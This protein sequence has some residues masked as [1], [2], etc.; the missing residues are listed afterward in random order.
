M[1]QAHLVHLAPSIGIDSHD[2]VILLYV[3]AVSSFFSYIGLLVVVIFIRVIV[4]TCLFG[5]LV[6]SGVGILLVLLLILV[7]IVVVDVICE[8]EASTC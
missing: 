1:S 5:W 2:L 4:A 3:V 7:A 8:V 6:A